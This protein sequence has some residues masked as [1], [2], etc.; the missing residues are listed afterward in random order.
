MELFCVA[1]CDVNGLKIVNDTKGHKAGDEYLREACMMV[2]KVFD[3]SPVYRTGGDEF[4]VIAT[5]SD[6]EERYELLAELN[7]RVEDNIA[8]GTAVIAAGISDFVAGQDKDLHSVMERADVLM[9]SR[10]KELKAMGSN[11]R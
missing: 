4:V 3:H 10:K 6:F 9:Y 2:C 5:G 7:K 1:V 11:S 8:S